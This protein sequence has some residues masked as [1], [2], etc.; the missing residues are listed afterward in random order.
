MPGS[1]STPAISA[2]FADEVF[3]IT[4]RSPCVNLPAMGADPFKKD[5]F[6]QIDWMR[7]LAWNNG[8]SI[9]GDHT[10]IPKLAALN[11][12]GATFN[13]HNINVHFDVGNNYQSPA[14]P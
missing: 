8:Y 7:G 2:T 1:A 14:S 6:V 11:A 9:G 13:S 4:P 5:I 12:I 10:H 3:V